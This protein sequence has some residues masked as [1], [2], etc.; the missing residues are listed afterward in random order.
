MANP[1]VHFEIG[2]RDRAKSAEFYGKVFNWQFREE[3]PA[4]Q[5]DTG[6]DAGISG[7]LTA[8]GHEPHHYT[9]FY[10]RVDDIAATLAQ[11]ESAGGKKLV[12][13]VPIPQGQFAWFIDPDGNTVGLLS[14][15]KK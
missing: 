3:G 4:T 11:V 5:V 2:C 6:A 7:H 8:V 9:T 14:Y 1:V 10:I 15:G 12:G 13:P